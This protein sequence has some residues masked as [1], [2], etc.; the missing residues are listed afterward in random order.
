MFNHLPPSFLLVTFS[1]SI[2][3]S[4]SATS[5]GTGLSLTLPTCSAF[6]FHVP[7]LA[8]F[9]FNTHTLP[10]TP[11][12][13]IKYYLYGTSGTT[14]YKHCNHALLQAFH[15]LFYPEHL[16]NKRNA[17]FFTE[18]LKRLGVFLHMPFIVHEVAARS[19]LFL[20]PLHTQHFFEFN[21]KAS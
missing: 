3:C 18:A 21:D 11:F 8:N 1:L 5:S 17:I 20:L 19:C 2:A 12:L 13:Y 9:Y 7:L 15:F 4:I 6:L 14:T 16:R 10:Y